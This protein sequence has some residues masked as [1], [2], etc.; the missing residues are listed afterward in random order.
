MLE[1]LAK[2]R[3]ALRLACLALAALAVLQLA[4][5]ARGWNAV[6]RIEVPLARSDRASTNSVVAANADP[7]ALSPQISARI[8]KIKNSQIL[9]MIMRPPPMALIGIAGQDVLLRA[10][11]GQTGVIR[12]G[13]ELGGI[14][15]LQIGTNR[16]LIEHAGRKQELMLFNGFGGESLLEKEKTQ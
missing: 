1:R 5:L 11:S 7:V 12:V 3:P 2:W 16:V 6:A 10:P 14:K 15:L 13:E 4:Q 8:E 9:G